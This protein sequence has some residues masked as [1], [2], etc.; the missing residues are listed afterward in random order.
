MSKII[1]YFYIFSKL[2]TS[3]VLIIAIIIMGYALISS[4]KEVDNVA[5]NLKTKYDSL[6]KLTAQNDKNLIKLDNKITSSDKKIGEIKNIIEENIIAKN[7][8]NY[9][10]VIQQLIDQNTKLQEQINMLSLNIKKNES[11]DRSLGTDQINQV[12]SLVDLILIKYKNGE[13][14]KDE[15]S[16][17]N[18]IAQNKNNTLEKLNLIILN[19]FYGFK[20][21]EKEFDES[22]KNYINNSFNSKNNGILKNFLF[23]FVD[24]KPNNLDIYKNKE[25]NFIMS[26]KKLMEK[27][28]IQNA[29]QKIIQIKNYEIYFSKWIAQSKLY[30]E[31]NNEINKVI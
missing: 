23:K 21:L 29:L 6:E 11:V 25:L 30:L 24:I 15:I 20:N 18:E 22:T 7:H 3:L 14:I 9:E 26:A 17:L 28:D 13:S 16:L 19:K 27:E 12:S 1:E 4:Y 31:F 8:S 2:S 5:L 10:D